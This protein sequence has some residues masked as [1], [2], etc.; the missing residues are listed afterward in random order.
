MDKN[1][2][3]TAYQAH[4]YHHS[5]IGWR[6]D[7]ENVSTDRLKEF[8]NVYYWPNNATATII[9]DFETSEALELVKKFFGEHPKRI[10]PY[11]MFTQLNLIKRASEGLSLRDLGKL[12]S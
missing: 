5:T 4:P 1:I 2:G 7:I 12:E 8:Y 10:I 11:P 6:S 9:G 3:A